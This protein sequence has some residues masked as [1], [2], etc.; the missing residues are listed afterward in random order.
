VTRM[1][2]GQSPAARELRA[3]VR[4]LAA[5]PVPILV[6]GEPGAGRSQ[7]ARAIHAVSELASLPLVS[8]NE[9]GS[10]A[11]PQARVVFIEEIE[12]LPR[13]EQERWL[14]EIRRITQRRPGKIARV[15][16]SA[17][18][19]LH[20]AVAAKRFHPE[21]W[22]TLSRF[23]LQ[24]PP[25]RERIDDL[26]ALVSDLVQEAAARLGRQSHGLSS[27]ALA[28]LKK[29]LWPGNLRELRDVLEEASAFEKGAKLGV[30]AVRD[31]IEQVIAKRGDSLETQRAARRSAQRQELVDLLSACG[32]NVAEMGRRLS[33]T[34]GAVV[35]RLQKHGLM[36]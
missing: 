19:G 12:R 33:L 31:A 17:G 29:R 14:L 26:D 16:A 8:G 34:R 2:A 10:E 20:D 18:P 15:L 3:R 30:T 7:V 28:E 35:Y 36:V 23:Q 21:L 9:A 22:N 24:I 5:L 13:S 25:L 27:A 6:C 32:G 4:A 1:I 11:P